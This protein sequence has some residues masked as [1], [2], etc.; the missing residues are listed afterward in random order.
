MKSLRNAFLAGAFLLL[1]LGI[2]IMVINF[3]LHT[4]GEPASRLFFGYLLPE[5]RNVFWINLTL[6]ILSTLIILVLITLV[7]YLSNYFLGRFVVKT[8]ERV[9]NR[10]PFINTVYKTVKQ[11]VTTFSEQKE[12]VFRQAVL[13]RFPSKD[14]FTIGFATTEVKD[15]VRMKSDEHLNLV[16]VFIPTTPSPTNGFLL[17]VPKAELIYLD[18]PAGEAIKFILSGGCVMPNFP[19]QKKSITESTP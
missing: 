1:P 5:V 11:I 2:T 19:Y 6:N 16:N 9:I 18:M 10:V 12:S 3:L 15:E 8:T 4:V 17:M 14:S 13:V 7:G